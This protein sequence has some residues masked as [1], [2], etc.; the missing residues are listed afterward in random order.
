[1]ENSN[2][3][4]ESNLSWK[5]EII[6]TFQKI[7]NLLK[8][9]S[10]G[11]SDHYILEFKINNLINRLEII[12]AP[13]WKNYSWNRDISSFK[14]EERMLP[15]LE[16]SQDLKPKIKTEK[17]IED[18]NKTNLVKFLKAKSRY[19]LKESA[20]KILN[21][22]KLIDEDER[23]RK[24]IPVNLWEF[25]SQDEIIFIFKKLK[26]F[27]INAIINL[28]NKLIVSW[29]FCHLALNNKVLEIVFN[30]VLTETELDSVYYH[31]FFGYYLIYNEELII[32]NKSGF[33]SRHILDYEAFTKIPI[34]KG[35]IDKNPFIPI[36][37]NSEQLKGPE[38]SII[39][40]L[41]EEWGSYSIYSV[42]K[43][44]DIFT[45]GIFQGLNPDK[46]YFTGSV[47]SA[48]LA[49]NPLEKLFGINLDN[50][51]IFEKNKSPDNPGYNNHLNRVKKLW[52][53][54]DKMYKK[55]VNYFDEYYPSKNIFPE[56]KIDQ[57]FTYTNLLDLEDQLSD[58]DIIID[59]NSDSEFDLITK[60]IF[61][62]V[63][64]NLIRKH[65]RE[66]TRD[67]LKLIE[68]QGNKS[69]KYYLSGTL[70]K[71]SIE[72]FRFYFF[73]PIGGVVKFHFPCVRG[74]LAPNSELNGLLFGK[75]YI[76]PSLGSYLNTGL[77]IDFRWIATKK[78]LKSLILKYYTRGASLII[79]QNENE[80]I[81]K[82][83]KADPKWAHILEYNA[84]NGISDINSPIFKPRYY[85]TGFYS[86][87]KNYL[88]PNKNYHYK[89]VM[90]NPGNYNSGLL[91]KWNSGRIRPD[92]I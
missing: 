81:I 59:T 91:I 32:G 17:K 54:W 55:L 6:N 84:R 87:I 12:S 43:R 44:F 7:I 85:L 53:K 89:F 75:I 1:M 39:P 40:Y 62:C 49:R 4:P 3:Y 2:I 50:D 21:E 19:G 73:N 18:L 72:I 76:T 67:E 61:S 16:A 5:A 83:I 69:Y 82:Y 92:Q 46:I 42:W 15:C 28:F 80:E 29:E 9:S 24:I 65:Q 64:S 23:P 10:I 30:Q 74:L 31:L 37:I 90:G 52:I 70:L 63:K 25:A 60:E 38:N 8:I 26:Y 78:S 58:I 86:E 11:D 45:D 88:I 51:L 22:A 71:R 34:F 56:I 33:N 27:K 68:V 77:L 48:C 41:K 36:T 66:L 35:P 57:N 13:Y 20:K 14:F 47:I 79:N